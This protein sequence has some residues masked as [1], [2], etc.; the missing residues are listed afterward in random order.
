MRK[1]RNK[2]DLPKKKK[3]MLTTSLVGTFFGLSIA[4][5][6]ILIYPFFKSGVLTYVQNKASK[7]FNDNQRHPNKTELVLAYIYTYSQYFYST[8]GGDDADTY[9]VSYNAYCTKFVLSCRDNSSENYQN[10][11]INIK[12]NNTHFYAK[13][14]SESFNIN[15]Y[16]SDFSLLVDD[17]GISY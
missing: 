4:I 16:Y 17:N 6:L 8:T 2:S 14:N 5:P 12:C 1:I 13:H 3:I 9:D 15:N 11:R 7:S 10:V